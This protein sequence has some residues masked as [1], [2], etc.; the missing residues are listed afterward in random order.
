[1]KLTKPNT[2][3]VSPSSHDKWGVIISGPDRGELVKAD[4][5]SVIITHDG[6]H[7][8][9]TRQWSPLHNNA[10]YELEAVHES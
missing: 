7:Y 3:H 6:Y 1:M 2:K 9:Y 4:S 5:T 10:Y 8:K